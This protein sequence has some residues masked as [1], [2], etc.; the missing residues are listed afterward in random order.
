MNDFAKLDAAKTI[1]REYENFRRASIA[2]DKGKM[3]AATR[4]IAV[5]KQRRRELGPFGFRPA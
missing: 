4:G 2:G 3:L 1:L 5:A